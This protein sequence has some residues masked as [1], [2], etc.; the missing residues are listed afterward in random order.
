M[1][2][3]H[4]DYINVIHLPSA[5]KPT[6]ANNFDCKKH[7]H[8]QGVNIIKYYRTSAPQY[9]NLIKEDFY[10]NYTNY[11]NQSRQSI[12]YKRTIANHIHFPYNARADEPRPCTL[13]A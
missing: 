1:N 3:G 13:Q 12:Y 9:I 7:M 5:K 6:A 8:T 4:V 10:T 11:G 2:H